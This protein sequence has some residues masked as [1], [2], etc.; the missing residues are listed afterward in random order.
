MEKL[1]SEFTQRGFRVGTIKHDVHGIE[2]DRLGKDSW[3]HKQAGA[4][5]TVKHEYF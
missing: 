3:Q 1:I 2:M 4:S 5:A